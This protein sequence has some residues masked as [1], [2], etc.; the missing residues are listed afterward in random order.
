VTERPS[1][2]RAALEPESRRAFVD[3]HESAVREAVDAIRRGDRPAFA[4]LVELYERRLFSLSVMMTRDRSGAEEVTQDAFV[5]AFVHLD[6][7]DERRPFYPWLATIAVRLAQN[8][9]T[10]RTRISRRE[11]SQLQP[12]FDIASATVDPLSELIA[13]ESDRAL[14]Q[15]VAA[16]PYGERTSVILYYRQ[17]MT[18]RD[19]ARAMGVTGGTVKTM[20]FRARHRLRQTVRDT[21]SGK[22]RT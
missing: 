8:W 9:L 1:D 3:P 5:R 21:R 14:W 18:V 7:Y 6:T 13:D 19:I 11:G 12:E 20:L 17:D 4:R 2:H 10:R 16:L 15:T 22:D